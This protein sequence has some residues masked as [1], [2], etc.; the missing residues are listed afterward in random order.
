MEKGKILN[1]VTSDP[2]AGAN[3]GTWEQRQP[4]GSI[5]MPGPTCTPAAASPALGWDGHPRGCPSWDLHGFHSLLLVSRD[6]SRVEQSQAF[7][8]QAVVS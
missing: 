1:S 8:D 6:C 7:S 5:A 3:P 4:L 2:P